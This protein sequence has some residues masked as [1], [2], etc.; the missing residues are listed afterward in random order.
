M[1]RVSRS[2]PQLEYHL[3]LPERQ[4]DTRRVLVSVHGVSRNAAE[5]IELFRDLADLYGVMLVAPVFSAEGYRDY[6]RLGRKGVGPRADLALIRLL[7]EIAMHTGADTGKVDLFGFSGGAQFA[8]RFAYVHS[9]RVRRIALGA[10][11]WYTMPDPS[12]PY[13]Y[14]TA[15]AQGLDAA[16]LNVAAAARLQT[17][18]MVGEFDD[19]EDDDELN[20][21]K[22]VERNQGRHRV[23]RARA[24]AGAMNAVADRAGFSGAVDMQL[25]PGVGHS[26]RKAVR[27]GGL[28]RHLFEHCYGVQPVDESASE[29]DRAQPTAGGV[30]WRGRAA[31][32]QL[33]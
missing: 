13:P 32:R 12:L 30:D 17:L 11:G 29:A 16:R 33:I 2:R 31:Y 3:Y 1:H 9:Q 14:G 21:A 8:H 25:L 10:A 20:R 24:W 19:R 23:E 6:Q 5:H 4:A 7:N 26:F 27:S 22:V 18:V 15:D 28:G